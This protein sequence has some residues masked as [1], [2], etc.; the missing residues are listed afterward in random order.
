MPTQQ[1]AP[2]RTDEAVSGRG[3]ARLP[4]EQLQP[5]FRLLYARLDGQGVG[6]GTDAFLLDE[7][8][9]RVVTDEQRR[10]E[11]WPGVLRVG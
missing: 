7:A 8:D 1:A 2:E 10:G 11:D 6:D 3:V 4:A 9:P 5:P